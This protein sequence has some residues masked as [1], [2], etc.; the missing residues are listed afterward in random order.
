MSLN[1]SILKL[2]IFS[3]IS[4]AIF[5]CSNTPKC[6]E[7]EVTDLVM[8]IS[9]DK[10]K[11]QLVNQAIISEFQTNPKVYGNPTYAQLNEQK[12]KDENIQKIID[13][14]DKQVAEIGMKLSAVRAN[15][16][17]DDNKCNCG[18]TLTL[19]DGNK[20]DITYT[21]QKTDDGQIYVEV[22]GL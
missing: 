3:C 18:C 7:T 21:A 16:D 13:I 19:S 9:T 17:S 5:G 15:S 11:N 10:L 22:F 14:V 1:K 4:I 6:S 2:I 12:S 8:E 20:A